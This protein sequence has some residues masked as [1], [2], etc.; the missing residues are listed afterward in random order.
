MVG[1]SIRSDILPILELGGS[2]VYV[3]YETTWLHESAEIPSLE[4]RGFYQLEN[5]GQLV[6]LLKKIEQQN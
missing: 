6:E 1:N 3:P 5:L 4:R 2:A